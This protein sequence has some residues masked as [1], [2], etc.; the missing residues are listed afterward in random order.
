MSSGPPGYT[1]STLEG[2]SGS[3][4]RSVGRPSVRT[5]EAGPE[6]GDP[7]VRGFDDVEKT[8]LSPALA[9][10][11]LDGRQSGVELAESFGDILDTREVVDGSECEGRV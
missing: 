10:R 5:P 6:G 4:V 3:V 8:Y 1:R 7:P 2:S 9:I 11:L